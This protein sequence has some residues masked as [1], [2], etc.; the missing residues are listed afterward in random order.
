M[1]G[2]FAG[3]GI[4]LYLCGQLGLPAAWIFLS[5]ILFFPRLINVIYLILYIMTKSLLSASLL[6][7][8]AS[9][10]A[11]GGVPRAE[12]ANYASEVREHKISSSKGEGRSVRLAKG[13]TLSI[14]NG[15]KHLDV[16]GR[17]GSRT[18]SLAPR[19][20][21][22]TMP[23]GFVLY[24]SFEDWDGKEMYW[25]PEGWEIYSGPEADSS[26]IW[27]PCSPVAFNPSPAQGAYYYGIDFSS[28]NQDEWIISPYVTVGDGMELSYWFYLSPMYLFNLDNVDWDT[29]E[30][31]GDKEIAATLQV[32]VQAEGEDWVE[33][34]DHADK[35]K[36]Y[37]LSD[38]A[39]DENNYMLRN[40]LSLK[41]YYGKKTRVAFRYV[42]TD[43]NTMFIDAIGIG[44]PSVE[45]VAYSA[46]F[47]TL[48]WGFERTAFLTG[49]GSAVA[50]YPVCTPLTWTNVTDNDNATYTWYYS[51][52]E[53][54]ETVTSTDSE[55][56]TVTYL[57]DYTDEA[58]IR[59]NLYLPPVLKAEAQYASSTEYQDPYELFQAGGLPGTV[60]G[61]GDD[62]VPCLVPFNFHNLGVARTTIFDD[63][64]G[65][66]ALPVFGYDANSDKYWLNYS[67]NG[68]E[69]QPGD[70]SKLIGIANLF[71]PSD[72][73]P[74]VVSGVNVYGFGLIGKDAELTATIYGLNEDMSSD[75]ETFEVMGRATIKGDAVISD[76][77]TE[78]NYL[79]LP[80]DFETPVVLKA[81]DEH[82]AYFIMLEGFNSD[83]VE[84]FVPLQSDH[85]DPNYYCWGY[86][87]NH[88]DLSNHTS[89]PAYYSIK[90][91]VYKEDGEYI[92]LYSAFCI[93]INAEYPWLTT[94]CESIVLNDEAPEAVV[95]LGSYYDGSKLTVEAPEG[96]SATVSGQYDKCRLTV[97]RTE[98]SRDIDGYVVVKGTGV[99]LSIPVSSTLSGVDTVAADSEAVAIY[100]TAGRKIAGDKPAPGVYIVKYA[101]GSQRKLVVK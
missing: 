78:K 62:F 20:A 82:P 83:K 87:M 16:L 44:L 95:A 59:S 26:E 2:G 52:P 15:M 84:Y 14:R 11:S 60:L 93:G 98:G 99:E 90:P 77:D 66:I 61:D 50:M 68:E 8:A 33:I 13:V 88:I 72:E 81:T 89:Q 86:I 54:G 4:N 74:L 17:E 65:D 100:D 91:M 6:L 69:A 18:I 71:I 38:L 67:L 36:D 37:T 58:T 39:M 34:Y 79:C 27:H 29:Y 35:Y 3:L 85:Q 51:D 55:E 41:D 32:W 21:E 75:I 7:I 40:T 57:P 25:T 80:F 31:I 70:Y 63:E 12:R 53:T 1:E 73:A 97:T 92:D 46:P 94:D 56:L 19:L 9:A 28:D 76:D 49:I 5:A 10:G 22:A 24:E 64:L 42:G 101:D 30:F 23:E 96:I 45:D 48:Y 47:Y 43:G